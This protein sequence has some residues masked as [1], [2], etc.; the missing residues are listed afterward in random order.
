MDGREKFDI[1]KEVV[2]TIVTKLPEGTQVGMRVYGHRFTALQKEAETD[3]ELVVP[4]APLKAPEFLAK[5]KALKCRGKTPITHSLTESVRDVADIPADV[6]VIAILLTDGG[7]STRGARPDEAAAKLASSRKGMK[8]HVVG[9]D[10]G[11][12][13][14]REQL[15][16]VAAAGAG[17]YVHAPK[18][19]ELLE[20][21]AIVTGG[22]SSAYAVLD[23]A[24]KEVLRGKLGDRHELPEGKY[25]FVFE[26]PDKSVERKAFWVNTEV[27]TH[28]TVRLLKK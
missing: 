7:E 4:F 19:R 28:V 27:V 11:D 13:S 1:A 9:F 22:G 15:E 17:A 23:K 6:D 3:S 14:W 2:E 21:L 26:R 25:E 12:E 20:A 18:A 8:V 16:A 24:G 5:L 10:I